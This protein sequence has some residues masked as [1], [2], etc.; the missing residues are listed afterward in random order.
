MCFTA[1]TACE[2]AVRRGLEVRLVRNEDGDP[3]RVGEAKLDMIE[4]WLRYYQ[5]LDAEGRR[6]LEEVTGVG[7]SNENKGRMLA[8]GRENE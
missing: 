8:L 2:D 6:R 1:L 7:I 5:G 4:E 3:D